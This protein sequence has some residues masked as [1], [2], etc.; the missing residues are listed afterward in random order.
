MAQNGPTPTRSVTVPAKT[1]RLFG[2][3]AGST[4]AG[5]VHVTGGR[6][7]SLNGAPTPGF[8]PPQTAAPSDG[9]AD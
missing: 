2:Q 3:D 7:P 9:D 4:N 1:G 5:G 6:G 8:Q